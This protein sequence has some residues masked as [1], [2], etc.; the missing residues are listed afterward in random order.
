MSGKWNAMWH[1]SPVPKYATAS[2]GHWLASAEQQPVVVVRVDVVAQLLQE[3]VRLGQVLAVGA[4]ALVEVGN[5]IEAQAVDAQAEPEVE[6]AEHRLPHVGGIEVEVGLMRVEAVPVVRLGDRIPAPV[7]RLEILE[8][9]ARLGVSLRRVAPHVEVPVAAAGRS[10]S[11]TLEPGMLIGGMVDHEFG[12]D[13]QAALVGLSEE[14]LEVVER[15]AVRMDARVVRDVVAVVPE[16]RGV[17]GKQPER[18]DP[19]VLQVVEASGEPAKVADAVAV[20]VLERTDPQLVEDRVLV[21]ERFAPGQV[22]SGCS[23]SPGTSHR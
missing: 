17:E 13:P 9:D 8:D 22:R 10:T 4:V 14:V 12:D 11:R 19:E 6:E 5:R 16:R 18:R 20:A 23:R 2:S 3:A 21:P 1:S 15:A 7:G